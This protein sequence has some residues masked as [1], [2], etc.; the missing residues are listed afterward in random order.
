MSTR[1]PPS[2][3]SRERF[4]FNYLFRPGNLSVFIRRSISVITRSVVRLTL[5]SNVRAC[6]YLADSERKTGVGTGIYGTS[7]SGVRFVHSG[8]TA[9]GHHFHEIFISLKN[10]GVSRIFFRQPCFTGP[11]LGRYLPVRCSF[12]Q[13]RWPWFRRMYYVNLR[14]NSGE[15]Q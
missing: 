15:F 1:E 14:R 4:T 3:N 6:C 10:H 2:H 5:I 12:L 9:I 8:I 13:Q 7:R 11:L